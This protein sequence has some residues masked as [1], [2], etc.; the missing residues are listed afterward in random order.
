MDKID[1]NKSIITELEGAPSTSKSLPPVHY[2]ENT[3]SSL[4]SIEVLGGNIWKKFP[5]RLI[6][7]C[8]KEQRAYEVDRR[9]LVAGIADYMSQDL[10]DF[11][12]RTAERIAKIIT[13]KYP[14]T[15]GDM[16]NQKFVGSGMESLRQQIYNAVNYRKYD[17]EMKRRAAIRL[18]DEAIDDPLPENV[19]SR[20]QDEYGCVEYQ[21]L[22]PATETAT[23]QLE[24]KQ[25]LIHFSTSGEKDME[26]ISQLMD[27]TY[28]TQRLDINKPTRDL[29]ALFKAW[30]YLQISKHLINQL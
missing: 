11:S 7:F 25:Q 20:K 9:S 14:K 4:Y 29:V 15:F 23:S 3:N 1:K 22:L 27:E 6:E 28:S 21:P 17:K 12:R 19:K 10:K 24:K 26:K 5:K 13:D 16:I 18:S 30:P 8:E 2:Q